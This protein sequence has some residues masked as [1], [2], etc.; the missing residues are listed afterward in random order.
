MVMDILISKEK[1]I[2]YFI[3][4]ETNMGDDMLSNTLRHVVIPYCI[5]NN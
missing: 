1:E 2:E 5:E 4:Y 3:W